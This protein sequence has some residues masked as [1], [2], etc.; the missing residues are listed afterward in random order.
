MNT[1]TLGKAKLA[2]FTLAAAGAALFSTKAIFIKLAYLESADAPQLLAWRMIFSL[3][4]FLVVG[5]YALA[6][7]GA[8][9][10]T[11]DLDVWIALEPQNADKVWAA[12][13]EVGLAE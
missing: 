1:G 11:G 12:L 7:H 13:N 3:P 8:P 4:F 5:A 6:V 2:G 9:R 10:A